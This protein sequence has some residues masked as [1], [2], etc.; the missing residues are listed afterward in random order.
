MPTTITGKSGNDVLIA[1]PAGST[2][3]GLAGNDSLIGGAGND[4]LIGDVGNDTLNGGDGN[5]LLQGDAGNDII[6]GGMGSDVA[7]F[8]GNRA[9]YKI[10]TD[11]NG[12]TFVKDL[13][14][15]ST[16]GYD[17]QDSLR[18]VNILR[19]ADGDISMIA[20]PQQVNSSTTQLNVVSKVAALT[21]GSY[22]IAWQVNLLNTGGTSAGPFVGTSQILAQRYEANGV[23]RGTSIVVA[24]GTEGIA[25]DYAIGDVSATKDGGF[26]IS[27]SHRES[28]DNTSTNNV[29]LQHFDTNGNATGTS[30]QLNATTIGNQVTPSSAQLENGSTIA[31]W[32]SNHEA[33]NSNGIYSSLIVNGVVGPETHINS[34]ELGQQQRPLVAALRS[35][36]Q[37]GGYVIAWDGPPDGTGSGREIWIQRF[38]QNGNLI[39]GNAVVNTTTAAIQKSAGIAGTADGGFVVTWASQ[40]TVDNHWSVM[41][42]RFHADGTTNGTEILIDQ[43][44][45]TFTSGGQHLNVVATADGGFTVAWANDATSTWAID[46]TTNPDPT[47]TTGQIMGRHYL[48]DGSPA[49]TAFTI[50]TTVPYGAYDVSGLAVT[51]DGRTIVS[52]MADDNK[53]YQQIVDHTGNAELVLSTAAETTQ[54]HF[55]MPIGMQDLTYV[56]PNTA[57]KQFGGPYDGTP[58]GFSVD[59]PGTPTAEAWNLYYKQDNPNDFIEAYLVGNAGANKI[60]GGTGNDILNGRGGA[61]TLVGGAGNDIYLVEDTTDVIIEAANAGTDLVYFKGSQ[62]TLANN[63]ENLTVLSTANT[64]ITGNPQ[65]NTIL[66]N[67]GNDTINGLAGNDSLVGGAGN[68]TLIGDVGNDTL[69]GGDGNDLLQGDAGAD[70]FI[71]G[72]NSGKDVISDF[73]VSQ[74]DKIQIAYGLNGILSAT[75]ALAKVHDIDGSAVVDL[76]EGA[77]IVLTGVLSANLNSNIFIIL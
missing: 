2:M 31:V 19:F 59:N 24:T 29:F 21:D 28:P 13:R 1:D 22:V 5:D 41:A 48:A 3:F 76:G 62:Y 7:V 18:Q 12:Q 23:P 66:G 47:V 44:L 53:I 54:Q 58:G 14:P 37:S 57:Y 27:Y 52:W 17:G 72:P 51:T 69:N 74:G 6:D 61:D 32:M 64:S 33:N 73:N 10:W 49:S 60:T 63:V 46:P 50:T 26:N 43:H 35:T 11:I 77:Q 8:H 9:D 67:N 36:N 38:D 4:T 70:K 40:S 68:D 20:A 42:Q 45:G 75:E 39:G 34:N 65:A 71:F 25:N 16:S 55:D 56:G 30:T 15:S